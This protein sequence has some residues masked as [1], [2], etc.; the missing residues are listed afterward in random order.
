[1]KGLSLRVY[2]RCDKFRDVIKKGTQG[3]TNIIHDP[4][5]CVVQKFNGCE[6]ANEWRKTIGIIYEPVNDERLECLFTSNLHLACRSYCSKKVKGNY[7]TYHIATRQCYYCNKY[8]ACPANTFCQHTK[9]CS[10]IAGLVYKLESN[11]IISFQDNF[12]YM[13]DLRFTVY[14]DFKTTTGDSIL[15]D[16]KMFV[17]SYCQI[18]AFHPDLKL[19]KRVIFRSFQQNADEVHS[20]NHFS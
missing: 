5:S 2:E 12:R 9:V 7:R 19:D 20:L 18:Y 16:P 10:G 6:I 3:K 17:M 14:F 4:L 11:K 13:G 8:F 15:H 1:M